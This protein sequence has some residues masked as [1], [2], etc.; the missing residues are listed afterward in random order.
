MEFRVLGPLEVLD[1]G[2]ALPLGGP[3]QRLVV[4]SLILDANRV[5]PTER[6]IDRIWGDEPPDAVRASL[7]A[8][9]SRLRKLLGADRIQARPPGYIL[10]AEPNEIDLI[11]FAD[12][13]DE[14]RSQTD[15]EA[16]AALLSQALEM[17][18]GD[19]LSDL[20]EYDALRP[21][22]ARLEEHRLG[23]LE[24]RI[25][26]D[27]ALGRHRETLPALESLTAENPLRER[28][29]SLLI[30]ALYRSGR[31]GD[32]LGAYHRA[33]R[34][35][36]EELG[37]DPSPDLQRLHEQV[38]SQDAALDRPT[39]PAVSADSPAGPPDR[40]RFQTAIGAGAIVLL[41]RDG[42]RVVAGAGAEGASRVT[43][44][45]RLGY[46]PVR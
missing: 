30:L 24:M 17:W 14:A 22:I 7:F 15:R 37:I 35:L 2:T 27:L 23:A 39:S 10:L 9:I 28:L 26:A 16:A 36:A 44:D 43:L 13:V 38:L 33:R 4:A 6:L 20:V 11:R 41:V 25:E 3:R 31:Q 5:V 12:L 32:A 40:R 42:G 34:L 29:W 8:Y 21:A 45:D 46:A 18:R 19:A 1:D